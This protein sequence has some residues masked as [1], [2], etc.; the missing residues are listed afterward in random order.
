M[1]RITGIYFDGFY[2]R[3][4]PITVHL[5][6]DGWTLEFADGSTKL[7]VRGDIRLD[8]RLAHL[9]RLACFSDGTSFE[10]PPHAEI[11]AWQSARPTARLN[12]VV[13]FLES[14]DRIAAV[15]TVLV[16]LFAAAFVHYGLPRL[17]HSVARSIPAD[18]DRTLGEVSLR[19]VNTVLSAHSGLGR[20]EQSHVRDQLQRILRG[21]ETMPDLHFRFI[22]NIANAFALPGYNIVVTDALVEQLDDD[23]LAA[24]LAHEVTHLESRHAEQSIL[25]SSSTLLLVAAITGDLST[26]TGFAASLPVVLLQKG[27]SRDL[28]RA[29]DA[30]AALRLRDAG[31]PTAAFAR[32][33]EKLDANVPAEARAYSYL[34]TH[35]ETSERVEALQF[36]TEPADVP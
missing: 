21:D 12:A 2:A 17:A 3:P 10:S 4:H 28:E 13:H 27:Y 20:A 32:A 25:H 34:N 6:P 1:S 29:A 22:G 5:H 24:V 19:S 23:E 16:V 33:L 36:S 15:A 26:L 30:G 11:D 8:D 31:I 18:M 35:P 7:Q 9:K 14:Y